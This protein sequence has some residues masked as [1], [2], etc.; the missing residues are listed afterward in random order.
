MKSKRM[1]VSELKYQ[2]SQTDSP[3]FSRESM[4]H[5]GDTMRNYGCSGKP[6][7]IVDNSGQTRLVYELWRKESVYAN[8]QTSAYFDAVTFKQ[9]FPK[10]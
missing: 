10:R 6:F 1:T 2:V 5:S 3:F 7:E 8:L 4:K 9:V